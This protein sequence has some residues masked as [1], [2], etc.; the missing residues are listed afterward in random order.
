MFWGQ[1]CVCFASP[2]GCC[3]ICRVRILPVF[4]LACWR[5][6]SGL[7]ANVFHYLPALH[8]LR[9]CLGTAKRLPLRNVQMPKRRERKISYGRLFWTR[10]LAAFA[11][12][13]LMVALRP[14]HSSERHFGEQPPPPSPP[15]SPW[16]ILDCEG[17][18]IPCRPSSSTVNP[19]RRKNLPVLFGWY[20]FAAR[21][22]EV[23]F[24]AAHLGNSDPCR[25]PL[26]HLESKSRWRL[27]GC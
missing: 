4:T 17:S 7:L 11:N 20:K 24:E 27:S 23:Q 16:R 5:R 10:S 22:Q 25:A 3:K 19:W 18:L 6:A 12:L 21:T 9:H 8:S 26:S 1:P 15:S 14:L 2:T 13:F